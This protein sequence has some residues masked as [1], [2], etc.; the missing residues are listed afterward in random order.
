MARAIAA[1]VVKEGVSER[2]ASIARTVSR[3]T[4]AAVATAAA[5]MPA[6][7][8][9]AFSA[10]T[11]RRPRSTSTWL[12]GVRIGKYYQE[13]YRKTV[14]WRGATKGAAQEQRG[15][16]VADSAR[17]RRQRRGGPG[18]RCPEALVGRRLA[19]LP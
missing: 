5:V 15:T 17:T 6:V 1:T 10:S 12:R 11:T 2:P 13:S 14:G 4:P 3:G 16:A 9:P 19:R 8:R 18:A 7:A